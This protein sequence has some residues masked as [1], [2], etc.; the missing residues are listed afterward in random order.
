LNV[1]NPAV[2]VAVVNGK[3]ITQATE[4]PTPAQGAAVRIKAIPNGKYVLAEG[5]HGV[6][7]HNITIKRVGK[8]LHVALEGSNLDHPQL[9]IE[10]FYDA[11]GQL[12]GMGDD[13]AYHEYISSDAEQDHEA[14]LLM[15]GVS[16]P[17]VLVAGTG[18]GTAFGLSWPVL[19]DLGALGL[20]GAMQSRSPIKTTAITTTPPLRMLNSQRPFIHP[21]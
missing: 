7:P 15:D 11:Q 1:K 4:L 21:L 6:A 19:L 12:V 16:A 20:A 13:G 17:Q 18:P 14:A 8:D 5:D 3:T 9:I 10:G 2:N